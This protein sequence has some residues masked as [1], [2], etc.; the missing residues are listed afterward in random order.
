[1]ASARSL[2]G[3]AVAAHRQARDL[4]QAARVLL[5]QAEPAGT[6]PAA[7]TG[8]SGPDS[9]GP[10]AGSAGSG[11]PG[12]AD[13]VRQLQQAGDA[14][15]PGWWT[16]SWDA[17]ISDRGF[18]L[19]GA[20]GRWSLVRIGASPVADGFPVVVPFVGAGHLCLDADAA[21]VR[22]AG[23]LRGVLLRVLAAMP[24]GSV[25]VLA[26]D[27]G[28]LGGT[29][30]PL[31]PLISAGLMT[32]PG[33]DLDGLRRVL[34]E[35]ERRVRRVAV[36]ADPGPLLV[37]TVAA[38][39][40]DAEAELAR[41]AVLARAGV[42]GGVHLLLAGHPRPGELAGS[43]SITRSG[44]AFRVGEPPGSERFGV[45]GEGLA[46]PVLLD[47]GPP[48]RLLAAVCGRIAERA[49]EQATVALD[50]LAPA[51]LWTGSAGPGLT[52]PIGR[53]L[54]GLDQVT[55]DAGTAHWLV[56][57][58]TGSGTTPVLLDLLFGL[59]ARYPPDELGLYLLDFADGVC[60]AELAPTELDPTWLPQ[61]RAVGI[62][63]DQ[64][65]GLA[66]L[67]AVSAEIDRRVA[68][69]KQAGVTDL[70]ALRVAR[71][72]SALPRL[73]VAIEEAGRLF[74]SSNRPAERARALLTEILRRGG[75]CGIHLV[76]T[77]S[78]AAEPEGISPVEAAGLGRISVAAADVVVRHDRRVNVPVPRVE[79]VQA[80]RT[81]LWQAR[82]PGH[83]APARYDGSAELHVAD[84]PQAQRLG[85]SGRRRSVLLGRAVELATPAVTFT[86]DTS[87]GRHLV[88]LG[89]S[90][91]G[92]DLLHAAVW[93]LCRQHLPGSATLVLAGLV[94]AADPAVED[95]A[96]VARVAGH[97][98]RLVDAAGLRQAVCD[99]RPSGP[100]APD[101]G[102]YLVVF[103][104][105]QAL[106][107]PDLRQPVA[108]LLRD[109]P[110][111]GV[112][113]LGWWRSP[114]QFA[115][116]LD[117]SSVAGVVALNVPAVE[118]ERA[119]GP[120]AEPDRDGWQ[121]RP[122]RALFLDRQEG[123]RQLFIPFVRP[124]RTGE[125]L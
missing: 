9:S 42:E 44:D 82:P 64:E 115:A 109:G 124:G 7:A 94:A 125:P 6:A 22:V 37:V 107:G 85:P 90:E 53:S 26:V 69:M 18:G 54:H 92:A 103:G 31:R 59:A 23:F 8:S 111:G 72:M 35:A 38:L 86:L 112:H 122:N 74:G 63:C 68:A 15:T 67:T 87:P 66:V 100:A 14:L 83:T 2:F 21:D 76:L 50:D 19:D 49:A 73:L 80:L 116:D 117:R 39:P 121:P 110:A 24:A 77:T 79:Q 56:T 5:R 96:T 20:P 16:A 102:N 17:P 105:D 11:P 33:T 43:T 119:L 45:A 55:L 58:R 114:A 106:T 98:V 10:G 101:R 32:E 95:A 65:Y 47:T 93:Q 88:L 91:V 78:A 60:F 46:A 84:D 13:L 40:P 4:Q 99:L 71:P 25:R 27:G 1:M 52:S 108:D 70:A 118:L 75:D 34:G 29:F 28:G 97:Q 41:L 3:R 123:R 30:A 12:L 57:G 104:G 62:E 51:E 113:L 61:L 120:P 81:R 48:A 89:S 36:G